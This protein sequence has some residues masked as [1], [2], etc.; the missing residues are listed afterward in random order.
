MR[1]LIEA[2]IGL[3]PYLG[4]FCILS[5]TVGGFVIPEI[6]RYF[7]GRKSDRFG[8][9]IVKS[10]I[11]FPMALLVAALPALLL[12]WT[13]DLQYGRISFGFIIVG[14]ITRRVLN[15]MGIGRDPLGG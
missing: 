13:V 2:I 10:A 9:F 11:K 4:T 12:A 15:I 8:I 3:N 5:S 7:S 14:F 1:S 6:S